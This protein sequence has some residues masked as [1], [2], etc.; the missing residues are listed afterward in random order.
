MVAIAITPEWARL[1]DFET[2]L[3]QA[4]EELVRQRGSAG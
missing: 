3:P 2:T 4:V 1:L